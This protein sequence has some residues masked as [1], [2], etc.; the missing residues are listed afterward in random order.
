MSPFE[1]AM[2]RSAP[3]RF[4]ARRVVLPWAL[5][6][7]RP[8]GRVL[9]IGAGS[10]AMAAELLATF[11]DISMC[12]TDVD[13]GMVIAASDR[14]RSF[15]DRVELR[16]AD[17]TALPFDDDSFDVVVSWIMLH[18]TVRWEQAVGE[19]VRV[20]RPGGRLVAYDLLATGP[21]GALHRGSDEH[22]HHRAMQFGELQR[23][24]RGMPLENV[25]VRRGR[26]G[27]VVRFNAKVVDGRAGTLPRPQP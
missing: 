16:Q 23:V 15:A 1:A 2:C 27:I 17:A 3:W 26:G 5:Q 4:V 10:G 25:S 9:E 8:Y 11:G 19:V 22:R 24:L 20:L 13:D 12:V 21:F 7:V 14:L 18:H 6:G